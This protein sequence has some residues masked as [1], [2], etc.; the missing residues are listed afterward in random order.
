MH[1]ISYLLL[2]HFFQV[3]GVA[4]QP[5]HTIV[6]SCSCSNQYHC[7]GVR[8]LGHVC[9]AHT[10]LL[11]E[12]TIHTHQCSGVLQFINRTS[13]MFAP[14]L[15]MIHPSLSCGTSTCQSHLQTNDSKNSDITVGW[16]LLP[17]HLEHGTTS[18]NR[19]SVRTMDS[20]SR[21]FQ[22]CTVYSRL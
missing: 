8:V 18:V 22:N 7:W 9:T 21:P 15:P 11:L 4:L 2:C 14:F 19:F 17:H 10:C 1:C 3:I 20:D 5:Q 12:L 13:A 16:D 6:N